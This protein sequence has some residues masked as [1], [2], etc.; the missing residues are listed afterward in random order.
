[1]A[2]YTMLAAV[3]IAY[4]RNMDTVAQDAAE[5]H[6]TILTGVPRFFEGALPR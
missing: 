3:T 2:F 1:M 6:P 5:V 4:A